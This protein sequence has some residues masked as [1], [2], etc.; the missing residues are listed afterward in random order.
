[1]DRKE[2]GTRGEDLA[3]DYLRG[4]GY[5]ILER[6]YRRSRAEIDVICEKEGIIVFVEVKR[7]RGLS[8]GEPYEAVTERKRKQII[9]AAKGYLYRR[10]LLG[11]CDVRFDVI[12]IIG[13]KIEHIEGAFRG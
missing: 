2:F 4:N 1:M 5:E 3:V 13:S 9:K 7:R 11:R 12:G 8:F 6:N 10:R